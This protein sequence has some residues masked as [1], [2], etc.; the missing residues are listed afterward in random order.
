VGSLKQVK[1]R[2][3]EFVSEYQNT[4]EER[5]FVAAEMAGGYPSARLTGS[6]FVWLLTTR[7]RRDHVSR[8]QGKA[9]R[10]GRQLSSVDVFMEHAQNH[11]WRELFGAMQDNPKAY[12]REAKQH[13]HSLVVGG[14]GGA[15]ETAACVAED[16]CNAA[17]SA[18]V[19]LAM[20]DVA[21]VASSAW[22]ASLKQSTEPVSTREHLYQ[23]GEYQLQDGLLAEPFCVNEAI[24]IDAYCGFARLNGCRPGMALNDRF[25]HIDRVTVY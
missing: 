14:A 10:T 7:V 13:V 17:A 15:R 24:V 8:R 4:A 1:D 3:H 20:D 21:T 23:V 22:Q 11:V 12:W 9:E 18:G 25:D 5:E 19:N 2:W 6:Y 16:A